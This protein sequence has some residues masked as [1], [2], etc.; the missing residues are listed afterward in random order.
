MDK[1]KV[2]VTN[3]HGYFSATPA[4][5]DRAIARYL[6]ASIGELREQVEE[7]CGFDASDI[8][9]ASELLMVLADAN[10]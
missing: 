5:L 3:G 2:E 10:Y 6:P 9:S 1:V 7:I 8:D 4:Q